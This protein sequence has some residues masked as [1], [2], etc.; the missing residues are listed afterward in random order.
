ETLNDFGHM[1][2]KPSH[3]E[4]LDWLAGWFLQNGGSWKELHRLLVTS[5]VYQQSSA[6][7][8]EYALRDADNRWLWR[9]NRSRLDAESIH[10]AL[11]QITGRLDL[12]MGGPSDRQFALSPGIHV[13]PMVD[14]GKFDVDSADGRR[15]SVYRFLFR[16]LPDPFMDSLDCPE[17]SQLTA[18]RGASVTALQALSMFNNQFVVRQSQHLAERAVAEAS[19]LPDQV[20]LACE[21]TLGRSPSAEESAEWNA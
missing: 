16:T 14:Y 3:P 15:R 9:M 7:R 17:G 12:T 2:G 18:T 19:S 10:D 13:T 11:L 20:R 8:P 4:L 1:G 21:L 5:A 6:A